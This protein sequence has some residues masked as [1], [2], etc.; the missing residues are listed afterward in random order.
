MP[1]ERVCDIKQVQTVT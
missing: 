1:L